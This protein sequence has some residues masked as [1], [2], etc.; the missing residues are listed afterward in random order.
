MANKTKVP[1]KLEAV[2]RITT[3]DIRAVFPE[4]SERKAQKWL[5]ENR[6]SLENRLYEFV[7]EII[8]DLFS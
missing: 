6:D 1:D 3:E 8:E 7:P 2:I 5:D 4:L